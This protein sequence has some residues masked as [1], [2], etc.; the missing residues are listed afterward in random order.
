[1]S[2]RI[3]QLGATLLELVLVLALVASATVLAFEAKKHRHAANAGSG[4]RFNA[5]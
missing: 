5:V 2:T 1:M 4:Y 3:A